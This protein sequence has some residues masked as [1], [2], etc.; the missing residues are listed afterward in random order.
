[1]STRKQAAPDGTEPVQES[2]DM[3]EADTANGERPEQPESREHAAAERSRQDEHPVG[4]EQ[5][6]ANADEEPPV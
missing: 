1:M 3:S 2:Q 5:A 4:E 6:R